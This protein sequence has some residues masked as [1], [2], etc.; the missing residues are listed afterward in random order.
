MGNG[1]IFYMRR[2][3]YGELLTLPQP[4]KL[5]VYRTW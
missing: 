5:K 2:I 3:A 4:T 1:A